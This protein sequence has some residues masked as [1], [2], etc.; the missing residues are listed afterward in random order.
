MTIELNAF[1]AQVKAGHSVEFKDTIAVI[2]HHYHY[3][4]IRLTNGLG[5]GAVINE[6]G[7]NEGSCKIFCFARLHDLSEPQT[8]ALFGGYYRDDVLGNPEGRDHGNIRNFMKYG[9][10]GIR[11]EG[12]ALRAI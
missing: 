12:E 10:G 11:I 3:T 9:W 4:P 6:P 2:S 7:T 5:E 1:L 8:L